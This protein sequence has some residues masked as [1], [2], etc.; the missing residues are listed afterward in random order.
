[1]VVNLAIAVICIG[2]SDLASEV[3]GRP[4][5]R[6]AIKSSGASNNVRYNRGCSLAKWTLVKEQ[7]ATT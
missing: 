1:M 6:A 2:R 7:T 3:V 4:L 5:T